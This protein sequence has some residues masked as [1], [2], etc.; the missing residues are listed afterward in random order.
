MNSAFNKGIGGV[1]LN[2]SMKNEATQNLGEMVSTL[3]LR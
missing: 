1:S 2:N 3:C